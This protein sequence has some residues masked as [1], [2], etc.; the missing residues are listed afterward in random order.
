MNIKVCT[1]ISNKF[2]EIEVLINTPER[3]NQV[4]AIENE[5]LRL[6]SNSIERIIGTQ[7]NDVYI[8]NLSDIIT[9]YSEE[10]NNFAKT[11]ERSI[12]N[13]GKT[14]LFGRKFT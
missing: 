1:N 5:L 9:F 3:T 7:G 6:N 12:Q 2:K 13:K 10:K 8:I 11:K 14:I 4:L